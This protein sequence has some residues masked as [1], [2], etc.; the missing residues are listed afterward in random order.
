MTGLRACVI[1]VAA[2]FAS[3]AAASA[4][5]IYSDLNFEGGG[6]PV[7][8]WSDYWQVCCAVFPAMSFTSASTA[9]VT[10][11]EVALIGR[12]STPQ[13]VTAS[14]WSETSGHLGSQIGAWT[15]NNIVLGD[16]L[17]TIS[18]ITGVSLTAGSSYFLELRMKSGSEVDWAYNSLYPTAMGTVCDGNSGSCLSN[19]TLGAF[20]VDG[21]PVPEPASLLL[22]T[23]ALL[24]SVPFLRRRMQRPTRTAR[25]RAR[26]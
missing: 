16:G 12:Q 8:D 9:S 7:A 20:E 13:S 21:T 23:T 14:L 26:A 3:A 22:L 15:I 17:Y 4:D 18:G 10:Q 1:A 6:A 25:G 2:F 24:G 19:Q 11:I 5:V